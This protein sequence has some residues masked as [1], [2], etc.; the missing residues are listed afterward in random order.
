MKLL[1]Q[2]SIR[3]IRRMEIYINED[4]LPLRDIVA[5]E[6]PDLI[7]TGVFYTAD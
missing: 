1:E 4:R 2:V 6:V 7:F 5:R 3:E